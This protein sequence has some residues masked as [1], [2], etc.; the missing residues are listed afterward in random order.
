M[1]T[2][3][4]PAFSLYTWGPVSPKSCYELGAC[5]MPAGMKPGMHTE[6]ATHAKGQRLVVPTS[7]CENFTLYLWIGSSEI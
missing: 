7:L 4:T 2:G 3:M 5:H 6:S 1:A